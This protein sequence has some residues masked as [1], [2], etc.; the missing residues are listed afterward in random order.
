MH[1]VTAAAPFLEEMAQKAKIETSKH[2]GN[3]VYLFTPLILLIIVKITAFIADLTVTMILTER[4]S[5]PM[6]IEH[7]MKVIARFGY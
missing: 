2:F 5:M 1:F 4:N 7:E 3:T 6:K